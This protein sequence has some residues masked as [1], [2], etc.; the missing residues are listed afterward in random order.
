MARTPKVVEDRRD[1]IIEA[2]MQVFAQKGF[3][4]ATNKDIAREAGITPGL[5]YYYFESK[6][7]LLKTII[8]TRSPAQL[9]TTLPPQVFELP[10]EIFLH[11][12]IMRALSIIESEQL[13][14]LIRMLLPELMHNAE[15]AP[16]IFSIIQRILEF[17]GTYFETQV[18]KGT[19]RRVNGVLTAQIMVGAVFSF[20][21]RRQILRDPTAL[22]FT[23]DQIAEVVSETVLQGILPR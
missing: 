18:E 4:R 20:V 7:D 15:M 3:T 1:Q 5:I 6:E 10:P 17:L 12:L 16:I 2:A 22:E 11:M 14:Q 19:L 21:L 8:E 9:I 23:H 13:I